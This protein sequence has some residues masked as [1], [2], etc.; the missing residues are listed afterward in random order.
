[1]AV[2]YRELPTMSSG[3]IYILTS[4][5]LKR[6]CVKIGFTRSSPES[7]AKQLSKMAAIPLLFKVYYSC[8]V[9]A[10]EEAERRVQK[11]RNF[12]AKP[13]NSAVRACIARAAARAQS[14]RL[15]VG[16]YFDPVC[17]S[18]KRFGLTFQW[19]RGREACSMITKMYK[20]RN[21]AQNATAKNAK[22][23]GAMAERP[24]PFEFFGWMSERFCRSFRARPHFCIYPGF[25]CA[26]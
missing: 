13:N 1:M 19:R 4:E 20:T 21:L 11:Q 7:R 12:S 8:H 16:F 15:K 22:K 6:T 2:T 14:P 24:S 9:N 17:G 23:G 5:S 25:R 3:H 26:P 18:G 10:A